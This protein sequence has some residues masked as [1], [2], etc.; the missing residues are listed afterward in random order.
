VTTLT[1]TVR[2]LPGSSAGADSDATQTRGGSYF[3]SNYPLYQ[4]WSPDRVHEAHEAIE[5]APAHDTP[6]GLYVHIPFCRKRCHFCYFKVYTDRNAAAIQQYIDAVVTEMRMYAD[7]AIIGG[8]KPQFVYFGGGTP[9]YLSP[10]QLT[11]LTDGLKAALPWDE[12]QEVTFECEPGTLQEHKLQAI[13]DMGVTRLSLGIENFNDHI[14]QTNGRAHL[15]PQIHRAYEWA[16]SVGFDQINIDLIAGMLEETT[17]NWIDCVQR[18]ID[19]A[20]DCVTIYQMEI[21]FNTTIYQQMKAE[22]KLTAPVADWPTKRQWVKYAFEQLRAHGYTTS[23]AYTMIRPGVRFLYRDALWRGADLLA[24][25]VSSFGHLH[26]THYQN[27][28]HIETYVQRIEA[29]ELPIQRALRID[30]EEAMIRQVILQLKEGSLDRRYFERVFNVDVAARF[31]DV[32]DRLV[33]GGFAVVTADRIT[34]D[35][36]ALLQVD[37]ML[38]E[39]FLPRH[40]QERAI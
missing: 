21:P 9:S 32:F 26:Q 1:Q 31:S 4:H 3:V 33:A 27:D 5:N 30:D 38:H 36:D 34:L 13:R 2:P 25:G 39:F 6:L 11:D 10:K 19:L 15:S 16:R 7:K 28:K 8:R 17:E 20:P 37:G 14:L 12:V 24:L 35:A 40:R 29:G 23:S 18:T 22:G